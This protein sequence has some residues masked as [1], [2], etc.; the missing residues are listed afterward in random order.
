M[1]INGQ[2]KN[3][4]KW[5]CVYIPNICKCN[6]ITVYNCDIKEGLVV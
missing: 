2:L 1:L 3:C 5:S 4:E 6:K